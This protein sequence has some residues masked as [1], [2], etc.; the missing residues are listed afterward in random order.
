MSGDFTPGTY[1]G[2]ISANVDSG[3]APV[4]GGFN[5]LD[6]IP[7]V[8]SVIGG[9]LGLIGSVLSNNANRQMAR[10]QMAFQE[11]M[12]ST[13]HQREVADLRAAGLN[14]ILSATHGGASSP[15]GASATMQN[16]TE[17][18][19]ASVSSSARMYGLEL[20]KLE[21]D[22]RLQAAQGAAQLANAEDASASAVLKLTQ[23]G[24]VEPDVRLK[25]AN[26]RRIL[27]LLDPE[28]GEILAHS[29]LM[30]AQK[31][32]SA[33]SAKQVA[34]ETELTKA[35]TATERAG[36]GRVEAESSDTNINIDRARKILGGLGE[37]LP[38]NIIGKT[39]FGGPA[40]AQ[41]VKSAINNMKR[42]K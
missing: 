37:V 19:G 33:A 13:A 31:E 42:R 26:T 10:D 32:V 39:L 1:V 5:P 29:A 27:Q 35:R 3:P 40:S 20:P 28:A 14:P 7:G 38:T 4:G 15:G 17:S 25:E 34:S 2:G 30:R 8:G 23:A 21:S 12:S 11:R 6:L 22:I 36:L 9:G 18:L 24:A 41:G 16:P